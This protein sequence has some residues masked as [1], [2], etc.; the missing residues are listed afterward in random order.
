MHISPANG[1]E[2]SLPDYGNYAYLDKEDGLITIESNAKRNLS[3]EAKVMSPSSIS[4]VKEPQQNSKNSPNIFIDWGKKLN[5]I[6]NSNKKSELNNVKD[7]IEW[8][9]KWEI[10]LYGKESSDELGPVVKKL[11]V[12][13]KLIYPVQTEKL[14]SSIKSK[15]EK[16]KKM[17]ELIKKLGNNIG[18]LDYCIDNYW[19]AIVEWMTYIRSACYQFQRAIEKYESE[20]IMKEARRRWA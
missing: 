1:K 9:K 3:T 20:K 18:T 14:L 2:F 16:E 6:F 17:N 7:L 10:D 15:A 19:E 8:T 5:S 13:W 12:D 4:E 11:E